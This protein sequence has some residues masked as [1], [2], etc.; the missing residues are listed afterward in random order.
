M[1]DGVC[2]KPAEVSRAFV[3]AKCSYFV[4]V[5]LWPPESRLN[6]DRWLSNFRDAETDHAVHLLNGFLYFSDFLVEEL[7][8]AAFQRLSTRI[9]CLGRPYEAA[10]AHWSSFRRNV[11][12]TRVTG[13]TPNET[14]SGYTFERLARQALGI[15][16][17]R[18]MSPSDALR[19][20]LSDGPAP[21]LFVDDFVGSGRQC[22]ETWRREMNLA[23]G[24][25]SSFARFST[26]RGNTFF[27]CPVVCTNPG[28]EA[29]KRECPG[30]DLWPAHFLS[31]RYS[32]IAENSLI[33]P[34]RLRPTA[35]EFLRCASKRAGILED[36]WAGYKQLG[37]TIAFQHGVPDATLPLFYHEG[38]GWHPLVRRT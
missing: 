17:S 1:D 3:L 37:L 33:W 4:D 11:M 7:F 30:L 27:Y 20:L 25:V 10:E 24:T 34:E 21:V 28:R 5:Q 13:E 32:A 14:D 26:V 35:V 2:I 19:K 22:L 38:N 12:V 36:G 6:P 15:D 23:N 9:G 8:K 31:Q 16:Q 18:I 29:I